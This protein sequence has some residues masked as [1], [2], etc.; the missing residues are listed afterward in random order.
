MA[1]AMGLSKKE[2]EYLQSLPKG[3]ALVRYGPHRS[4]VRVRPD[5]RDEKFIDT[6]ASMRESNE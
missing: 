6:D 5:Q 3:V 1:L 2:E 4:I